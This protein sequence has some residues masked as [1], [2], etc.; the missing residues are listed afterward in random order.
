MDIES[1]DVLKDAAAVELIGE[2]GK[3]GV[4]SIKMKKND[5]TTSHEKNSKIR[6]TPDNIV[7]IRTTEPDKK[8]HPLIILDGKNK[9]NVDIETLELNSE[10]VESIDVLKEDKLVEP[11]GDAGKDGVIL[12][13]SK[14]SK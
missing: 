9:G 8:G 7:K 10:D 11:Y 12:I 3:N 5:D 14:K 6:T 13:K 1:I 2:R 4:I